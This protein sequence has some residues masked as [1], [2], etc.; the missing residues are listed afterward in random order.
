VSGAIRSCI[1][2]GGTPVTREHVWPQWLARHLGPDSALHADQGANLHPVDRVRK[3]E[4]T[5]VMVE[6]SE[7]RGNSMRKS[8]HVVKAAC[9]TCN[10]GWM[11][12]L[13]TACKPILL[14]QM[15][16]RDARLS[17]EEVR[18]LARW[19][20]KTT[21]IFEMDDPESAVLPRH[22]LSAL[23]D[24][25]EEI[26][27]SWDFDAMWF[28]KGADRFDIAHGRALMVDLDTEEQFGSSM[29]QTLV[30]EHA[31]YAVQYREGLAPPR[32]LRT[33]WGGRKRSILAAHRRR[34]TIGYRRTDGLVH[35]NQLYRF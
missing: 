30:I 16:D 5:P 1:F 28:P 29:L 14:R 31:V 22:V 34:P 12:R 35:G 18:I 24:E 9:G 27:G 17:E 15:S 7:L 2:C 11:A 33:V 20:I 6:F 13:E 21:A 10:S 26:P 4:G 32:R 23:A 25:A 19:L 3:I 8:D